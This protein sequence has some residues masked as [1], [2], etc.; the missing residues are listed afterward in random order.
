MKNQHKLCK[1]LNKQRK[2]AV[3]VSNVTVLIL[4]SSSFFIA[5]FFMRVAGAVAQD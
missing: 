1:G 4:L 5:R 2:L 3:F